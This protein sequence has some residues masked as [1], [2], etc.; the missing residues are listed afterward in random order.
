MQ[1]KR[2]ASQGSRT[3]L[4]RTRGF[5]FCQ[6]WQT[7]LVHFNILHGYTCILLKSFDLTAESTRPIAFSYNAFQKKIVSF[8]GLKSCTGIIIGYGKQEIVHQLGYYFLRFE[9]YFK[10]AHFSGRF[11]SHKHSCMGYGV[12]W[13]D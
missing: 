10:A 13:L 12:S 7:T 11:T 6:R 2:N 3:L 9:Y 1:L 8:F 4:N 5:P